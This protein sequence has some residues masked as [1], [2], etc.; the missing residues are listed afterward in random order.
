MDGCT[1]YKLSYWPSC[2]EKPPE[3]CYNVETDNLLNAGCCFDDNTTYRL[4][5]FGCGGDK[6]DPI[7]QPSNMIFSPC[8][9]SH[10]TVNRVSKREVATS[11]TAN[12]IRGWYIWVVSYIVGCI[13]RWLR[14][15]FLKLP[16]GR[17][18]VSQIDSTVLF[19]SRH[20]AIV[21]RWQ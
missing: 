7:R 19:L 8:P 10:D 17:C 6:P 20:N 21:A 13:L 18:V 1:T 16:N 14:G 12:S 5:Y 3:P 4:S 9:L 11:S 15:D 2:G